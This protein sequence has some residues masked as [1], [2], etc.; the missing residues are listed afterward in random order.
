MP[1]DCFFPTRRGLEDEGRRKDENDFLGGVLPTRIQFDIAELDSIQ[2][3]KDRKGWPCIRIALFCFDRELHIR[4]STREVYAPDIQSFTPDL[5]LRNVTFS[6]SQEIID[7]QNRCFGSRRKPHFQVRGDRSEGEE[8]QAGR[9]T[10]PIANTAIC[11]IFAWKIVDESQTRYTGGSQIN[12]PVA[13][14][15]KVDVCEIW[16]LC[17]RSKRRDG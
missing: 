1:R 11:P 3:R 6:V 4:R 15:H 14:G 9:W 10:E 8:A 2:L 13:G 5:A 7:G 17:E 16:Y 12:N